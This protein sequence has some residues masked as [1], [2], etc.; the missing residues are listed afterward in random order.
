MAGEVDPSSRGG[1]Y[2]NSVWIQLD[3][4]FSCGG[5]VQQVYG[6]A[7]QGRV[8]IDGSTGS[9]ADGLVG[10]VSKFRVLASTR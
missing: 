1:P 9:V 10:Y 7:T 2:T 4:G 6:V 8:A 3:V 5:C